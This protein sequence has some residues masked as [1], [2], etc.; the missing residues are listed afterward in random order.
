VQEFKKGV[1]SL[2]I[3]RVDDGKRQN[4][5]EIHAIL[6]AP[7]FEQLLGSLDSLCVFATKTITEKSSVIKTG[8]RHSFAKYL[9]LPVSV[10]RKIKSDEYDFEN[11]KCGTVRHRD[12]IYVVYG[13]AKKAASNTEAHQ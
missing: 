7:E 3:L 8:A 12:T 5:V 1:L 6:G 2:K 13:I 4:A 10:R 11:I 9:L